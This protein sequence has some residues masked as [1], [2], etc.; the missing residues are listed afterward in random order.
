[1]WKSQCW[2]LSWCFVNYNRIQLLMLLLLHCHCCVINV[3]NT[4]WLH[5]AFFSHSLSNKINCRGHFECAHIHNKNNKHNKFNVRSH[6]Q[7]IFVV[8]LRSN[9]HPYSFP[10]YAMHN[11]FC[12]WHF[13]ELLFLLLSLVMRCAFLF[14]FV[15][16]SLYSH[17]FISHFWI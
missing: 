7:L 9:I 3:H 17:Y 8:S 10:Y 5:R 14:F 1:M 12:F 2:V 6:F 15:A 13:K 4:K 11:T 16:P